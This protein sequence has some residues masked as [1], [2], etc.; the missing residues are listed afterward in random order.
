MFS[1][2]RDNKYNVRVRAAQLD[3][4]NT[5]ININTVYGLVVITVLNL[6]G[7]FLDLK[8]TPTLHFYIDLDI[9]LLF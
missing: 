1:A 6:D 7:L 9:H 3:L 4:A 8:R 5:L 2:C